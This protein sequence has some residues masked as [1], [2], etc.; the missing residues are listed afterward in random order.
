MFTDVTGD[1]VDRPINGDPCIEVR[2]V[3]G[4]L[5]V[6]DGP[7]FM[8]LSISF[9]HGWIRLLLSVYSRKIITETRGVATKRAKESLIRTGHSRSPEGMRTPFKLRQN[10]H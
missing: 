9:S 3:L 6:G 7:W 10:E 2:V 8:R 5:G 1:V 4:Q